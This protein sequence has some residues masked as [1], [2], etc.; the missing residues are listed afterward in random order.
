MT[1]KVD[2]VINALEGFTEDV[3]K[4]L[5]V[6]ITEIIVVANP[7]DTG[8]SRA[9]WFLNIGDEAEDNG[10]ELD[11]FDPDSDVAL[12]EGEQQ[13]RISEIESFYR[14]VDG[15][16]Y[17]TNHTPYIGFLNDGSSAQAPSGF[18]QRSIQKGI[19]QT[20]GVRKLRKARKTK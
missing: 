14:L 3:M 8:F 7:V 1:R 20:K 9:R 6:E 11:N 17:I 10:N 15:P 19:R 16:I 12:E 4:E 2:R 18:V 13:L 5:S